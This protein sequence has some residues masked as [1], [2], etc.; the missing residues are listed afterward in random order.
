MFAVA[1]ET[2]S[3]GLLQAEDFRPPGR[4]EILLVKK[5]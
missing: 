1:A 4:K 3:N 2:I 5:L